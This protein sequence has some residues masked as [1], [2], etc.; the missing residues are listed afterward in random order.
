MSLAAQVVDL[1]VDPLDARRQRRRAWLRIGVPIACV[2]LMI[3]AILAISFYA[4]HANRRG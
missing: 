4:D 3:A 1:D 2:A